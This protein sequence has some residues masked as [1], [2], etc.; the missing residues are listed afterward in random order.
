MISDTGV[1]ATRVLLCVVLLAFGAGCSSSGSSEEADTGPEALSVP[2][3]NGFDLGTADLG[4]ADLASVGCLVFDETCQF[5]QGVTASTSVGGSCYTDSKGFCWLEVDTAAEEQVIHFN[6]Q[7]FLQTTKR[8]SLSAGD[9]PFAQAMMVPEPA[10]GVD[11]EV[12][13]GGTITFDNGSITFPANALAGAGG[14]AL[15]QATVRVR[16]VD[17]T[18]SDILSAPGDFTGISE[19]Q[20]MVFLESF[21]MLSVEILDGKGLPANFVKG[22][23]A[24]VELLVPD[25]TSHTEGTVVPGWH[26][27]ETSSHWMLEGEW[28][29][30]PWT[31]DPSKM[32]YTTKANHFS[33]VNVDVPFVTTCIEGKVTLCDGQPAAGAE[34]LALGQTYYSVL[35]A[36]ANTNGEYCVLARGDS[37]LSLSVTV[38]DGTN[39]VATTVEGVEYQL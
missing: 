29:V 15:E 6:K 18:S 12:A 31:Q 21:G 3:R 1:R 9:A 24:Q 37:I 28:V 19:T 39:V 13:D 34:V 5:V 7:G 17:V 32:A 23:A 10:E 2:P 8:I 33:W 25:N 36:N 4:T 16:S 38:F 22:A 11:L 30:A 35:H 26:F 20:N 14:G 27:D